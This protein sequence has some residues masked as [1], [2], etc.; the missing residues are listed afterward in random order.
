MMSSF[1]FVN[2]DFS[3]VSFYQRASSNISAVLVCWWQIVSA[4]VGLEKKFLFCL[5]FL[6]SLP[7][8]RLIVLFFFPSTLKMFLLSFFLAF[9]YVYYHFFFYK[10][11]LFF[12]LLHLLFMLL[13]LMWLYV[14]FFVNLPPPP[15]THTQP[16][17]GACWASSRVNGF[18]VWVIG[19][20]ILK[21]SLSSFCDSN[22]IYIRVIILCHRHLIN[23]FLFFNFTFPLSHWDISITTYSGSLI[24]C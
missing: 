8:S 18:I 6:Q 24:C 4:L 7:I 14:A 13:I 2:P 12:P 21:Y 1:L 11:Y 10:L 19:H 5:Q 22:Y 23:S 3:L 20:Y 16:L 9:F 15:H 17:F